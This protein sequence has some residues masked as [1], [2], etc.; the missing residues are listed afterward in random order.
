MRL[1]QVLTFH[2]NWFWVAVISCGIVGLWGLIFAIAKWTP[3]RTFSIARGV[4]IAAMLIQV[5]AGVYLYYRGVRP[6]NSFHVF[7]GVVIA[8]TFTLAY[9]YRSTMAKRPALTY[10]VLLLFV[11]G[12]GLRAWSNVG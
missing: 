12:L 1:D 2:Q 7:Y 10:G 9:L 11:M 5:G 3:G 4:A 6:G 8:V